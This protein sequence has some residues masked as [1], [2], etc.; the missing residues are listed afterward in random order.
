LG[1]TAAENDGV[2]FVFGRNKRRM[3]EKDERERVKFKND[4]ISGV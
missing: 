4:D 3:N 2:D 1:N